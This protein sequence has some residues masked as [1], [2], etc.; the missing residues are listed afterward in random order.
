MSKKTLDTAQITEELSG[1]V[2][3]FAYSQ[4]AKAARKGPAA[5]TELADT[6]PQR[7]PPAKRQKRNQATVIPRHR[8]TKQP[9]NRDTTQTIKPEGFPEEDSIET[10]RVA[11]K[12]LGKEAATYRFTLEEKKSLADV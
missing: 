4:P 1:A 12:Q 7:N 3:Q 10:V 5:P 11:V 2:A 8:D 9:S 6:I